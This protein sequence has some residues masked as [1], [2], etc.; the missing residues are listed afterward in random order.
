M[1]I[2]VNLEICNREFE[3]FEEFVSGVYREMMRAGCEIVR[4]ALE[5]LDA[6]L[7]KKRDKQRFRSKGPRKTCIKTIMGEV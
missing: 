5:G 3:K 7:M 4:Q 2:T 1:N 6:E